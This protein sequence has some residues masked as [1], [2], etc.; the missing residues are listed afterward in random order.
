MH[1]PPIPQPYFNKLMRAIVEFNLIEDGDRILI[2]VS[3]G[4][5]S[6]FLAY[7]LSHLKARIQKNFTMETLTVNPIFQDSIFPIEKIRTYMESLDLRFHT[8]DVDIAGL[9]DAHPEKSPCYTCAFFRRGSVNRYALEH[10]FNKVAYAHHNDDAVETLLMGLLYSGQLHTFT[11]KTYLDRTNLYVIRPLIYFR[12]QEIRDAISV[13]GMEPIDSPCL[14]D[15][16]TSRQVIKD[17]IKDIEPTIPQVYDHL[18]AAM[19]VSAVHDLWPREKTRKEMKTDY[20]QF[21][22]KKNI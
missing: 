14:Y 16:N 10:G 13:H 1:C 5:D 6:L 4:K 15:G 11:P 2:G 8:I 3:G 19:R 22:H 18:A 9:I 17:L 7:A 12:E 20:Y 21:I